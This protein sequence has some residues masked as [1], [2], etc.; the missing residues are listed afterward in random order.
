MSV[1]LLYFTRGPKYMLC[2]ILQKITDVIGMSVRVIWNGMLNHLAFSPH[3]VPEAMVT[4]GS[5]KF[6]DSLNTNES[7]LVIHS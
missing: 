3:H 7:N 4:T 1:L 2:E 6:V 5:K